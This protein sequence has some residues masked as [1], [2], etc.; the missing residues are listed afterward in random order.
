MQRASAGFFFREGGIRMSFVCMQ[1]RHAS[2]GVDL[3]QTAQV[4][5][6]VFHLNHKPVRHK[7]DAVW[8]EEADGGYWTNGVGARRLEKM[9]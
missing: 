6:H 2:R 4:V 3:C 8:T 5:R 9:R 7:T 1:A